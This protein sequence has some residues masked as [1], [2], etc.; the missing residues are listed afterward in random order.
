MLSLWKKQSNLETK[1]KT[2][3]RLAQQG[4]VTKCIQKKEKRD[5]QK[6]KKRKA[7]AKKKGWDNQE[8]KKTQYALKTKISKKKK[9]WE[10]G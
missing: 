5:L 2:I 10:V 4:L 1:F 7:N 6:K 9:K 3:E 8:L